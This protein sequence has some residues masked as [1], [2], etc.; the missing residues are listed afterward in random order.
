MSR[1]RYTKETA[2]KA[3]ETMVRRIQEEALRQ[4]ANLIEERLDWYATELKRDCVPLSQL[5]WDIEKIMLRWG[6]EP[7]KGD[8]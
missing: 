1:H 6:I 3:R 5:L 2:K 4:F 7:K 8:S